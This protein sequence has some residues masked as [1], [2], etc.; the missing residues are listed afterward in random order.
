MEIKADV[1]LKATRVE[2]IYDADPEKWWTRICSKQITYR[3][4][5]ARG[6]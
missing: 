6:I 1:I 3:D 2:G 5:L 4:V